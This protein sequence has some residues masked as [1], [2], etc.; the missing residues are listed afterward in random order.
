MLGE[1]RG[2]LPNG[3]SSFCLAP[4]VVH[5]TKNKIDE[6]DNHHA[7]WQVVKNISENEI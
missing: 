3:V 7:I 4:T 5:F 6:G 2:N 1:A